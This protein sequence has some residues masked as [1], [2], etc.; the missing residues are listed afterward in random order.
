[1]GKTLSASQADGGAHG[2][3]ARSV[4]VGLDDILRC[5]ESRRM[6]R[7]VVVSDVS[8]PEAPCQVAGVVLSIHEDP[9]AMRPRRW[10]VNI[11]LRRLAALRARE[12]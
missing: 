9:D 3:L 11:S 1:M 10:L 2:E 6:Q 7:T 4:Y 5:H 8:T 12:G